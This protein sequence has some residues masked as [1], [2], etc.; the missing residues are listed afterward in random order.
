[1]QFMVEWFN[2]GAAGEPITEVVNHDPR[3]WWGG[4]TLRYQY[5]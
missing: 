1:M 5:A 3:A 4:R 2:T